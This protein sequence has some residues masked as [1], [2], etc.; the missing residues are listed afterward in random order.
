MISTTLVTKVSRDKI[1]KILS[2]LSTVAV[3]FMT[4]LNSGH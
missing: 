1:V 3:M 4:S 2:G